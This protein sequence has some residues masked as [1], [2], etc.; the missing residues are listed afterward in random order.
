MAAA[1]LNDRAS[2]PAPTLACLLLEQSPGISLVLVALYVLMLAA[3]TLGAAP[4]GALTALDPATDASLPTL[5]A[6]L[7]LVVAGG[8]ALA[9]MSR[10]REGAGA[11]ALLPLV[12]LAVDSGDLP[13]RFADALA[14]VG[15]PFGSAKLLTGGALGALAA[16]A[17]L[18]LMRKPR[19]FLRG[20]G[21]KC[22]LLLAVGGSLSLGFDL[23]GREASGQGLVH[24][25]G[26][27]E[28]LAELAVYT[29]VASA[30]GAFLA[31]GSVVS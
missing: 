26:V 31:E 18:W 11:A 6:A 14:T 17:P 19:A 7:L 22:L 8:G 29:L 23:L 12:L 13:A 24:L 3:A 28:E 15:W 20:H 2:S 4:P 30:T 27:L 1:S 21:R 25:M 16:L 9:A 10:G 5:W